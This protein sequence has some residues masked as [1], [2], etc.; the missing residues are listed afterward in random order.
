M[1]LTARRAA[2]PVYAVAMFLSAA[3]IF[4]LQPMFSRMTTPLL[5]GSPAVWN[6]S[7]VFFQGALLLGY[8]YAHALA[9]VGSVSRQVLI[10]A[11]VLLVGL[12]V[13]P[14]RVSGLLGPPDSAM[15]ALWLFGVLTIS[16]GL[17]YAAAS[18]TAPLLQAWF[19]RTGRDDAGDP[20]YLYAASN[21]GSLLGLAAY[22]VLLE[23]ALG[24]SLQAV[25]WS[26]A[27]VAVA[28]AVLA[29]GWLAIASRGEAPAPTA[30]G[31]RTAWKDR[32]Y[33]MAAAAVPSSLLLAVTN[34]ISTDVASA[35][36]LWVVPLGLYLITFV[37]AF[38]KG[39]EAFAAPVAIITPI[40]LAALVIA[41]TENDLEWVLA[42]HLGCFFFAALT[43]HLTLNAKRPSADRLTEFY[44]W[45]SLGG[46]L[47]GALTALVAP[48]VFN[49]VFE[50]PIALAAAALFLPRSPE[51]LPLWLVGLIALVVA[52]VLYIRFD[53]QLAT[54]F[55]QPVRLWIVD[56]FGQF[57]DFWAIG[58]AV[59]AGWGLALGAAYLP[60]ASVMLA[61]TASALLAFIAYRF[62]THQDIGASRF[63][64]GVGVAAAAVFACR[65]SPPL[66]AA[67][68]LVAFAMVRL[69]SLDGNERNIVFQDRSFFG[70]ARVYEE[71]RDDGQVRIMMHGTTI[72]GAQY[73]DGA[74]TKEPLTYYSLKTGLGAASV[75]AINSFPSA[76][77]GLIGLGSGSTACNTRPVDRLTIFEIDP[78]VVR[79]STKDNVFTYVPQCQP[80]AR[81]VLG[82]ARLKV[83]DEPDGKIDVLVVDAFSSDAVP[84][85]LLTQEAMQLYM[86][87]L[88]P[89]G[90]AILHL[91]NRNLD[92][93]GEA[94]RVVKAAGLFGINYSGFAPTADDYW[95][96]FDT[97][98]IVVARDQATLDG[99]NLTVDWEPIAPEAGRAWS[100]EYIN[101]IRPLVTNWTKSVSS[102]SP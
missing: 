40:A 3:L 14:I 102:G 56:E 42:A 74:R 93:V 1:D 22:P 95:S 53:D 32:L 99:L 77:V 8:T 81:V 68:V 78:M 85:H 9:R 60:R 86:R 17:P 72:H 24:L 23:P 92:L 71:S 20:Y 36:F 79:F 66:A 76:H 55:G 89:R 57:R 65:N 97:S 100:D 75:A 37:I 67:M 90:V 83:A 88:S 6:T 87:K 63:E 101:L 5:G 52:Y 39:A 84:A 26:I 11:I 31:A 45:V 73:A 13:L 38:G 96:V 21:L 59:L 12:V 82:D 30:P 61:L 48:V 28:A 62:M 69:Y 16:V 7:M 70:V 19:S 29:A 49:D 98:V 10:H 2:A 18:A 64:I 54:A 15:P 94:A 34:H 58:L 80:S 44:M 4:L 47:G 43:C 41:F 46:V 35:P 33:W 91:S 25:A 27:Y 50:Y 51:K